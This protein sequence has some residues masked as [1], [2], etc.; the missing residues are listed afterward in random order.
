M[1]KFIAPETRSRFG[2]A[3]AFARAIDDG[4]TK[5][6]GLLR[7]PDKIARVLLGD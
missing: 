4:L 2:G 6:A 5:L 1:L 3:G 7:E